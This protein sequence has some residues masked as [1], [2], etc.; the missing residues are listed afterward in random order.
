[1]NLMGVFAHT[2][3]RY[4]MSSNQL[5]NFFLNVDYNLQASHCFKI[6]AILKSG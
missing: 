3:F 2:S 1:M 6:T 5:L 4:K